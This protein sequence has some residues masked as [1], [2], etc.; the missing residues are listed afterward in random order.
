[1]STPMFQDFSPKSIAWQWD[2]HKYV[3]DFDYH[4]GVL[5]LFFSGGVGSAKTIEH[6]HEIVK[7]CLDQPGSRWL[8]LRRALK[9]LKRTSWA[10]LLRHMADIPDVIQSYNKSDLKITF[11]NGSE[12]FGD[13]Y[14]DG[15]LTKFQSLA[16]SGLDIEEIN[17]MPNKGIYEGIK[18]R[19]G[20]AGVLKNMVFARCN[21]DEPDHWLHSYFIMDPDH[22]CKKVFYSLTEQNPFLPSWYLP[23]QL[24]DLS[25]LMAR[26]KLKGEWLSIT[27][28]GIYYNYSS[29]K[30]FKRSETYK[31]DPRH[32]ISV[33][34]DFNIGAGKPMSVAV[35]QYINKVFH[36]KKCYLVEGFKTYQIMDEMADDGVFENK[37]DFI[38]YGDASGRNNSTSSNHSDWE[39]IEEFLEKYKRKDGSRLTFEIEVPKANPPIRQRHNRVNVAFQN[40]LNQVGLYIYS[41]AHQADS[42]FRLTKL[43]KGSGLV[44]DDSFAD[45]HVSGAIGYWIDYVKEYEGDLAPVTRT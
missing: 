13:S 34:H 6:I 24:R 7:N 14:D 2:A 41:E 20:R 40:G 21:P 23:N 45:Q 28:S 36:I 4:M 26:R 11:K 3:R 31:I 15:D 37:A 38:I 44:E 29:E 18:L 22:P 25:P 8:M 1:M 17:E 27:G 35:G 10:E 12:I 5:E 33:M 19:L 30:N 9:D 32:P 42:G 43:K 16:L 39:I